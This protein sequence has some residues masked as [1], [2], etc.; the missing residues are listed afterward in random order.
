M[1]DAKIG[2]SKQLIVDM[3]IAGDAYGE[4]MVFK[5]KT[6]VCWLGDA[7]IFDWFWRG[8]KIPP[9]KEGQEWWRMENGKDKHNLFLSYQH[10]VDLINTT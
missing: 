1:G 10:N 2:H 6:F 4:Q 8:G 3:W 9:Q 5:K 7:S